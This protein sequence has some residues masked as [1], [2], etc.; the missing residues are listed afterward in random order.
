MPDQTGIQGLHRVEH[1]MGMPIGVDVRDDGIDPAILDE[2]FDWLRSVDATFSTYRPDSEIS[3]LNAGTLRRADA[4]PHVRAVLD[5]C[6]TL[7]HQTG[8]Y[9]D[10]HAVIPGAID[11][12]G[13]VKGWSIEHAATLLDCAGA[14]AYAINAG[15]DVRLRGRPR[16]DHGWRVGIQHP[17]QRDRI[18]ALLEL[19]DGAVAT[20]G[21]YERGHHIVTPRTRRS[22]TGVLSVTVVGPDLATADAYATAAF[23]MGR[24]GPTWT[25]TLDGY[26]AMTILTDETVL[27][28]RGFQR[29]ARRRPC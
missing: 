2:L 6:E 5:R 10:A 14:R 26:E 9:F 20:S 29:A 1:L 4:G 23:A 22:P 11:P 16:P 12:T 24:D 7:R 25:A 15:G 13:L 21:A 8:G 3:R 17:L 27:T 28:T 18:A 19:D